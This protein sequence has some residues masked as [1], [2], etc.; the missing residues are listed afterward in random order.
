MRNKQLPEPAVDSES[1]NNLKNV[2]AT[3]QINSVLALVARRRLS[4]PCM[5]L[6]QNPHLGHTDSNATFANARNIQLNPQDDDP[7][8]SPSEP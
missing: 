6:S 7:S 2:L 1:H 4:W 5:H 3:A 8:E